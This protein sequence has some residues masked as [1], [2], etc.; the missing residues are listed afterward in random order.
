MSVLDGQT[1]SA[2]IQGLNTSMLLEIDRGD[3]DNLIAFIR[4]LKQ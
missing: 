3:L 4:S 1:R 2:A